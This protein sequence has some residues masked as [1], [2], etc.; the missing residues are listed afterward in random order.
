MDG[1]P[2]RRR[3]PLKSRRLHKPYMYK[4]VFEGGKALRGSP[5]TL[6]YLRADQD[7]S[8]VGFIIRKKAGD[9][10][11]RN[12][13]RRTLRRS[14]QELL[15]EIGE[16]AWMIFDVSDKVSAVSRAR[17]K[18]EADRLLRAASAAIAA[19]PGTDPAAAAGGRP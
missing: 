7:C 2:T 13:I 12:S 4:K 16:G 19:M 6:R 11:M 14:F 17:V 5:L 3:L 10:P 8:R 9:A 18:E 1:N 15:P